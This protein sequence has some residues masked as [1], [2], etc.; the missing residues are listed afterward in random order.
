GRQGRRRAD[1]DEQDGGA[2]GAGHGHSGAY[3]A[4]ADGGKRGADDDRLQAHDAIPPVPLPD[5]AGRMEFKKVTLMLGRKAGRMQD[6]K[7]LRPPS[8]RGV[9]PSA[10]RI[11][12]RP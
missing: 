4:V 8:P 3:D 6:R 7:M 10:A 9:G 11:E 5:L 2:G 12:S 1:V